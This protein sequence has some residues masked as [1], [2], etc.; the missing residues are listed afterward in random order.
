LEKVLEG[1]PE[2]H[3]ERAGGVPNCTVR[4]LND[5]LWKN[6]LNVKY[7]RCVAAV[8]DLLLPIFGDIEHYE[9]KGPAPTQAQNACRRLLPGHHRC[10]LW[11]ARSPFEI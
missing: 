8:R 2:C 1:K 10:P 4:D 7:K 5:D 9:L 6:P 11:T 3:L